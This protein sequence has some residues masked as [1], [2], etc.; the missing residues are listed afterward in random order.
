MKRLEL[1]HHVPLIA[2]VRGEAA[3][4]VHYGSLAVVASSGESLHGV[5]DTQYPIF[6]RSTLKPFQALPFIL[7]GGAGRF[8]FSTEQVALLCASHSGEPRHVAAV[9][10]MLA[11]IGCTEADLQCGCHVPG[12]YAATGQTPPPD[13]KPS[14]LQNNC[15]GKHAGF[16]AWCRLHDQPIADY[17]DPD[18]PLQQ[19]I[20]RTVARLAGLDEGAMPMG[21]D[22]C[23]APIYALPPARLAYLYARLAGA[24]S[25]RG[26]DDAALATLFTAMSAHP[27]MVSG[28]GR[29][30]L[31]LAQTAPGDWVAKGGAD[32]VQ[33]LGIRSRGVGVVIK[34]ADGSARAL[35][36]ATGAVISQ[37]GLLPAGSAA[38]VARWH[39]ETI[40]NHAGRPTG[41]IVAVFELTR[42]V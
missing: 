10:D 2:A 26:D 21:I 16:L 23:G 11:R 28:R 39:E 37:L 24:E 30:D 27:E 35:R 42:S 18:H 1:P 17:L 8:G 13:L 9:A 4:S 41:R 33:A 7:D 6:A 12:F 40:Y 3:E 31:T 14:P 38:P 22:G 34:I 32:G 5:G 25:D 19:T 29:A 15:S 36:V 20:R